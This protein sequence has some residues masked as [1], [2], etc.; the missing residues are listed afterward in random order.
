VISA[1]L[2]ARKSWAVTG[3]D[4]MEPTSL[5]LNELRIRDAGCLIALQPRL[6]EQSVVDR[7]RSELSYLPDP[8]SNETLKTLKRFPKAIVGDTL[9]RDC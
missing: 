7:I 8:I 3:L 1:L 9:Q 5:S 4:S 6:G 2:Y